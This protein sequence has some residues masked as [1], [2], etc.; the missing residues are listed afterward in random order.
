MPS[1]LPG[2][3]AGKAAEILQQTDRLIRTVPEVAARVRQDRTRRNG[4]RSRSDGDGGDH[5]SVQAARSVAHGHDAAEA[6]RGAGSD[7]EDPGTLQHLG[8]AHPQPHRHARHRHQES[9]GDQGGGAEPGRDRTRGSGHRAR[10]EERSR[11]DLGSRRA[12]DRRALYRHPHR[13]RS[14]GTLRHERL[15]RAGRS[16]LPLSVARTSARRSRVCSAF[17]STCAI[18]RELRDSVEKLRDLP[19]VTERGA[20]IPL[21][22]ITQITV[23]DGPPMLKSENARL[24]G[25]VYVDIRGR[26][27]LSVVRDAQKAVAERGEAA[28]GLFDF[29]VRPVRV[30]GACNQATARWWCRSRW[31]SSSCC[32]T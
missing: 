24:S 15:G 1:A 18:P 11:R 26:D 23:T 17:R 22:A 25:W 14:R 29:L 4:D 13:P 31:S 6:D 7:R 10:G 3:S 9:A 2:L 8:A 27:L 28:T 5:H 20:Q 12:A 19:V 30:P 32:C 21:G 16:W